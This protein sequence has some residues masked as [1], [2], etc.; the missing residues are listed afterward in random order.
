MM[1]TLTD[2]YTHPKTCLLAAKDSSHSSLTS[3]ARTWWCTYMTELWDIMPKELLDEM[4]TA[5]G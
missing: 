2:T 3:K 4:E 1:V 5:D